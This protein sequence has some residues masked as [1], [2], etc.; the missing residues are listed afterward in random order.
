MFCAQL[1][2]A[3]S[4]STRSGADDP[5]PEV[6]ARC[7]LVQLEER[8]NQLGISQAAAFTV[9]MRKRKRWLVR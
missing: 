2:Q 6:L 8:L 7:T 5:T 9:R 1:Q 4:A 3:A